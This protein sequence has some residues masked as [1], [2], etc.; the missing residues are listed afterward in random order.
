MKSLT[1]DSDVIIE[2]LDES[3]KSISKLNESLL[4]IENGKGSKKLVNDMFRAAHSIKG[5]SGMLSFNSIAK[6]THALETVL[7]SIRNNE[8]EFSSKVIETLFETID[9]LNVLLAEVA[10]GK[11]DEI[12]ISYVLDKLNA[13]LHNKDKDPLLLEHSQEELGEIPD[14][15]EGKL[16]LEDIFQI[17]CA[18]NSG[19]RVYVV[20]MS[21]K[22]VLAQNEDIVEFYNEIGRAVNVQAVI[23]LLKEDLTKEHIEEV[24]YQTAILCFTSS[25]IREAFKNIN[26][27]HC[28]A[29]EIA[30]DGK[31]S[32]QIEIKKAKP[33]LLLDINHEFQNILPVWLSETKEQLDKIDIKLVEWEEEPEN[34]SHIHELFRLMHLIKGSS[35]C[36]GLSEFSRIAHNCESILSIF[37]EKFKK[38]DDKIFQVLYN[39]KDYLEE[40]VKKIEKNEKSAPDSSHLNEYFKIY[41]EEEPKVSKT[42]KTIEQTKIDNKSLI[43]ETAKK[44][45]DV[46]QITVKMLPNTLMADIRYGII[47]EKIKDIVEIIYS[48]PTLEQIEAGIEEPP[49]L[50]IVF[51][52]NAQESVLRNSIQ[53]DMIEKI[54]I[55]KI[56]DAITIP[57]TMPVDSIPQKQS[58]YVKT[59]TIRVDTN[60]IDDIMNMTGELVVTKA[61]I[62][63]LVDGITSRL[64]GIDII[65]LESLIRIAKQVNQN[66][67]DDRLRKIEHWI[68]DLKNLQENA[69]GL[70]DAF[71][72][73]HKHTS[74]IQNVVINMRMVPIGPLFQRFNRLVRDLGKE[75]KRETRL[76]IT[77]ENTELDKKLTDELYDPLTHLIRNAVDHGLESPEERKQMGK[78]EAGTIFLSA[79]HESGQVC[80]KIQDDGRGLNVNRIKEKALEKGLVTK[81]QADRML[82]HEIIQYIFQPGFSTAEKVTNISGRGVGMD[83]VKSKVN[84]L[85]G[86]VDIESIPSKGTCFTIRLPLTLA[87]IKSLLV[88]I[89]GARCAIPLEFVKEILE[90]QV[91][92]IKHIEGKGK[93]IFLRDNIIALIYLSETIY[94]DPLKSKDDL[95]QAVVI[96]G[97]GETFAIPVDRILWEEEIV[98]KGLPDEFSK[99][100]GISGATILGDGGIALILDVE[101]IREAAKRRK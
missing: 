46:W 8:L 18:K 67:S 47:L 66:I 101:A 96:R 22:D 41:L 69:Y 39:S 5:V 13:I 27:E 2:F 31:S 55:E 62:S 43:I 98:I 82:D 34:I 86:K 3:G 74:M 6:V 94:L 4:L 26:I 44:G 16:I 52:G 84:E 88:E 51:A 56:A 65:G 78:S 32:P 59:D 36:M 48:T 53:V 89:G 33:N 64:Y 68:Q 58:T 63:Q 19:K 79:F 40:C 92:E 14:F 11:S 85:K 54:D 45:K 23:P 21:L 61:R 57:A 91:T 42:C 15:L 100:S 10:A 1:P 7:D 76:I 28:E 97:T 87:M 37:R 81:E 20:K 75:K 71:L 50:E 60:R 12:N 95:I 17:L 9:I 49:D 38:A 24:D 73:L 30:I 83:I 70:R 90:K 80:I 72:A 25:D 29:W 77:G 35:S 99:V 93:V